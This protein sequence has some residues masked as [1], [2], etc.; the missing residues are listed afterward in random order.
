MNKLITVIVPVYN[1]EAYL[2]RCVSSI[3]GQSYKQLEIILVNDG[4]L[5][6][7]PQKCDTWAKKDMRIRVIHKP[8]G[9]LASARNAA[10]DVCSGA[11]VCFVDSDDYMPK[12]AIETMYEHLQEKNVDVVMGYSQAIAENGVP[13]TIG[14]QRVEL[15]DGQTALYRFLY[16]EQF[17]GPVWGKLYRSHFFKGAGAVR[18]P[19]GLNSEDY[20]ALAIIYSRMS[21]MYVD[22]SL[23]YYYC[24]RPDSICT[25][26]EIGPHTFDK[27]AIA[28]MVVQ[29]LCDIGY[30]DKS[31][32]AYFL[33]QGAYDVL[34]S[35]L[36]LDANPQMISHYRK[37]LFRKS[38]SVYGDSRISVMRKFKILFMSMAP[39]LYFCFKSDGGM[40]VKL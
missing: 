36:R 24:R 27:L 7:S 25:T 40:N 26:K 39:S 9:G 1:V 10:L 6:S 4:S 18:F 30:S 15:V 13:V 33:M 28:D 38:L 17:T 34:Y 5:D 21:G 2:D 35:L 19:E 23:V 3:V 31:A 29:F 16:H 22:D 12:N 20:Y 8:N 32:M 37:I 14:I 11:Y